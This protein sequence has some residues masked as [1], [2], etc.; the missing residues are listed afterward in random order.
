MKEYVVT[1]IELCSECKGKGEIANPLWEEFWEAYQEAGK[2]DFSTYLEKFEYG[3]GRPLGPQASDCVLCNGAGK[4]TT[5]V[6]L[7]EALR[8]YGVALPEF[9]KQRQE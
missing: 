4:I 9:D 5:S 7:L 1:C 2:P 8:A 6:S 3:L